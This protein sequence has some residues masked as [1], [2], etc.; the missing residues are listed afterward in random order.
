[1]TVFV[2]CRGRDPLTPGAIYRVKDYTPLRDINRRVLEK[3]VEENLDNENVFISV[4]EKWR[5]E[6]YIIKL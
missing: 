5:R 1:V 3:V 6:A 4:I 2:K